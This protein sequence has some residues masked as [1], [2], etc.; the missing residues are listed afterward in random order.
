MWGKEVEPDP[1][2]SESYFSFGDVSHLGEV[3]RCPVRG[4]VRPVEVDWNRLWEE[5]GRV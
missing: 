5:A 3:S 2:I 4:V 1:A